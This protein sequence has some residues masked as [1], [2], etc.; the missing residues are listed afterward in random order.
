MSS[1]LVV[2]DDPSI[3]T[4]ISM[5]LRMEGHQVRAAGD[6]RAGLEAALASPPDVVISDL[7]MPGMSGL[8]LMLALRGEPRL[9]ATRV[10]LLT[11]VTGQPIAAPDGSVPDAVLTK[12]FAREQLL[13]ALAA[14]TP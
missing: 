5:L 14:L 2:D 9:A 11:G 6:G 7:H 3:R 13:S 10:L 8:E 12:P 4:T 1:V